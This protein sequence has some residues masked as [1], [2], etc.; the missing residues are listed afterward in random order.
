MEPAPGDTRHGALQPGGGGTSRHLFARP[1][2]GGW[3]R[4]IQGCT[5][6]RC[7]DVDGGVHRRLLRRVLSA[8]RCGVPGCPSAVDSPQSAIGP[9][10]SCPL[11]ARR[12]H[13][14]CGGPGRGPCR[15]RGRSDLAARAVGFH[16]KP[17]HADAGAHDAGRTSY[18]L[19]LSRLAGT[20]RSRRWMARDALRDRCRCRGHRVAFTGALRG[21]RRDCR[22]LASSRP[23]SFGG[24]VRPA[25]I[26]WRSSSPT[27]IM[28]SR[29][30]GSPIGSHR[31]RTATSKTWRRFPWC[32]WQRWRGRRGRDGGRRGG[33][34]ES[35][36]CLVPWP[37]APLC[38]W[39]D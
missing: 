5:G 3:A 38:M 10:R 17:L 8:D 6:T 29:Q 39:P 22:R 25:S 19:G 34:L 36:R 23:G 15:R 4:A 35:Q 37:L 2:E 7:G 28:R 11:D 13:P 21:G 27:R 18:R 33:G 14:V 26:C 30:P 24:A 9:R 20:E 32:S 1:P 16:A 12:A 31:C